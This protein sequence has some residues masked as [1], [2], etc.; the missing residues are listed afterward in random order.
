MFCDSVGLNIANQTQLVG[1]LGYNPDILLETNGPLISKLRTSY[2][3]LNQYEPILS[4]INQY[5]ITKTINPCLIN[6]GT[7][8]GMFFI[9][10]YSI[11]ISPNSMIKADVSL[12]SY[13]DISGQTSQNTMSY[14][15][16][17][18]DFSH[19]LTSFMDISADNIT[20][21]K[22]YS[23]DYQF[24]FQYIPYYSIN[25]RYPI[26]VN[27]A[28][29]EE[30]IRFVSDLYIKPKNEAENPLATNNIT[31]NNFGF[32]KNNIGIP[33]TFDYTNSIFNEVQVSSQTDDIVKATLSFK[34]IY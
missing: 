33:I 12:T 34:N 27:V 8:S 9:D 18:D 3:L 7:I 15:Y 5:K 24:G 13:S 11:Q 17:I 28:R 25:Q 19:A 26:D 6:F 22:T 31:I 20:I 29:G 14:N 30:N 16:S 21:N 1:A 10:S 32:Y 4:K 23:V 2:Y